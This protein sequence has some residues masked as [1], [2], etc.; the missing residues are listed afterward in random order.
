M[1]NKMDFHMHSNISNDGEFAPSELMQMCRQNGL[2]SVALSDHNSVRGIMEAQIA[3]NR[4]GIEFISAIELDCQFDEVNLHV[5]GYGID[6]Q[7]V[8]FDQIEKDI[9]QK[10][11]KAS[12]YIIDCMHALGVFF[13]DEEVWNLSINGVVT[14]EMI[15][16]AALTDERNQNSSLLAPYRKGGSRSDNPF[17]NF[18]W[19]FF[20][21][22]KPADARFRYIALC[23]AIRI[24]KE[25][26]GLAVLAH[27]GINIGLDQKLLTGIIY[28]G[29]DGIEVFS[30][31]H[32]AASIAFFGDQADKFHLIKTMGSDFH[33]KIK[34][35]ITLGKMNC[36]EEAEIYQAFMKKL[37]NSK[38]QKPKT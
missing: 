6:P 23:E 26:G 4:L 10:E 21:Q 2:T 38:T 12:Y 32:D 24:I 22:G 25:A 31:Y 15:A 19:D 8:E 20:S 36:P 30:S 3:A 5:L 34:P 37:E 33:G 29:I 7:Q 11:Q 1:P 35:S 14:G 17:V 28:S 16:E 27:P 9:L 18:Y 13:E